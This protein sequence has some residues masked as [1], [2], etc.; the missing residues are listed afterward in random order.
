MKRTNRAKSKVPPK[1][2]DSYHHGNLRESLISAAIRFLEKNPLEKLSLRTLAV[3][4]GVS[5][6]AP[7]RHFKDRNEVLAAISQEGFEL[8]FKYMLESFSKNSKDPRELLHGCAQAY[9]K[10]GLLHPQ[11]FKLML[12]SPVCPSPEYPGLERAA[13]MAFGLLKKIIEVCQNAKV[14]GPGD[15]YHKSM[16]CWAM[17]NGFTTLYAEGR[18]DWLG[19]TKDNASDA[20]RIFVDQ[21]LAGHQSKLPTDSKFKVFATPDAKQSLEHLKQAELA[22]DQILLGQK[23][24]T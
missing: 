13:G 17:V 5:Q 16:H 21:F 4:A 19:V 20:L 18:L 24:G 9:F 12:T 3:K 6:A 14:V 7:Y 2:T 22:V 23:A 10:M 1:S 15:P 11:H 8:K